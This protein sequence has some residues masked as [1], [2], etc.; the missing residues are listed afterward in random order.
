M[1]ATKKRQLQERMEA[2]KGKPK[3]VVIRIVPKKN[4]IKK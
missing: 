1:E 3:L 4:G 2:K